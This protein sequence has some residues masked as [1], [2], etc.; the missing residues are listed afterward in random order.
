M[1]FKKEKVNME[2]V[3]EV[4]CP[5]CEEFFGI[6]DILFKHIKLHYTPTGT[7]FQCYYKEC[8]QKFNLKWNYKRHVL[9]HVK[10]KTKAK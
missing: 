9:N 4:K 5:F 6:S 8:F 10:K 3:S 7:I 2:N 1:L